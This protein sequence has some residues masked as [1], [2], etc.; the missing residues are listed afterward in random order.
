MS[1][2]GKVPCVGGGGEGKGRDEEIQPLLA[3]L[4]YICGSGT[5]FPE[6]INV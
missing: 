5:V 2:E 1:N 3:L 4:L 6:L